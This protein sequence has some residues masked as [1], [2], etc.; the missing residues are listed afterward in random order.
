MT[1]MSNKK[2]Q[3]TKPKWWNLYWILIV[4]NTIIIGVMLPIFGQMPWDTAA[5]FLC[6]T[7]VAEGVAYYGRVKPSVT[8]N[9]VM[10]ILMGLP[11]GFV[12]WFIL[13]LFARNFFVSGV[14]WQVFFIG[15][16]AVCFGVGA[17]IGDRIGRHRH[18]KGPE[19]YQP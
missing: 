12:L 14:A 4:V 7:L 11:I 1:A 2:A 19:Q 3:P 15:S 9:R 16:M 18:Y 6:A 13:M 5:V 8:L 17:V 10:Y